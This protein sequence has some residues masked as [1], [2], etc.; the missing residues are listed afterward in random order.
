M[1]PRAGRPVPV[2]ASATLFL[3]RGGWLS[4]RIMASRM[5]RSWGRGAPRRRPFV[6]RVSLGGTG[7]ANG[8]CGPERRDRSEADGQIDFH[9]LEA[10]LDMPGPHLVPGR[11]IPASPSFREGSGAGGGSR[12]PGGIAV[13]EHLYSHTRKIQPS[14][15]RHRSSSSRRRAFSAACLSRKLGRVST[16]GPWGD[17]QHHRNPLRQK[18]SA[19]S[20]KPKALLG[21]SRRVVPSDRNKSTTGFPR[22]SAKA[23]SRPL[24]VAGQDEFPGACAPASMIVVRHNSPSPWLDLVP[25]SVL[26]VS[27][28]TAE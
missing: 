5:K 12:P 3:F 11:G 6:R 28:A 8:T 4:L 1:H 16:R 18:A 14:V 26:G 9:G 21:A 25:L 2:R 15:R 10:S 7:S 23:G 13:H 24:S 17:A 22:R 19:C 27:A 20:V